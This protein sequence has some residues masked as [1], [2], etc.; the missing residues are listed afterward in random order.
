MTRFQIY[1]TAAGNGHLGISPMPGR[2]GTFDA[3]FIALVRWQPDLV[4]T[5][6]T[7]AELQRARSVELGERLNEAACAWRHLPI[8]DFGAPGPDTARLWPE[9][10]AKAR[11]ILTQGGRVLAHCW[12]GQGRSGMAALRLLVEMGEAPDKALE[13]IRTVRPGAVETAEQMAWAVEAK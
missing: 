6:T 12:A 5:M 8:S 3:D 10:S 1:D 9:A 7:Q 13:R 4:L 11:H 2:S